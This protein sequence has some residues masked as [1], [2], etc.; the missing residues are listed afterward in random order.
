MA[1]QGGALAS[2]CIRMKH[3]YFLLLF[4]TA[5]GGATATS[6]ASTT[7]STSD[8]DDRGTTQTYAPSAPPPPAPPSDEGGAHLSIGSIEAD[9]VR[10]A[11]LSCDH[12]EGGVGGGIF[13]GIALAAG[14]KSRK[15][16]LDACGAKADARVAWTGAGG[17]MTHVKATGASALVNRCVESALDGAPST[18]TGACSATVRLGN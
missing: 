9:G 6:S 7:A 2:V 10:L 14:F 4:T 18:I 1:G 5:C 12:V 8:T 13:G 16:Q 11:D 15:A 3:S 17:A